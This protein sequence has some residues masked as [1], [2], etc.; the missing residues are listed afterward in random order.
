MARG[1]EDVRLFLGAES[2]AIM[3]AMSSTHAVFRAVNAVMASASGTN[4]VTTNLDHP[5]VYDSSDRFGGAYGMQRRVARL[6]PRTGSVSSDA[7][8]EEVDGGTCL[9]GIVHASNITGA[10][11]DVK[12]I[13]RE[14]RMISPDVF[15]LVD[16]VQYVPHAPV[17]VEDLGIDAYVFGPYKAFCVKGIG[18]AFLSDRLAKLDHWRL[19]GKAMDDWSLG[20]PED[21]T[22]AAWSAVVDYLCWLGSHFTESDKRRERIV[23]AMEACD[24]HLKALLR[25]LLQGTDGGPGLLQMGH[26]TVHGMDDDLSDRACLVL[27]GLD[28]MDSYQAVEL[29]N[30]AG[31]RL[32]NRVR[33]AY[34]RHTLEA[35]GIPGGVRLSACHYNTPEEIDRFLR[36][37]AHLGEISDGEIDAVP[38]G[39]TTDGHS[40]G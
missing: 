4:V 17:D 2:G 25:R 10:V 40:E 12:T 39:S 16:G 11:M 32:H 21:A 29:Y 1:L 31:F 3:P 27:F 15:V 19:V 28:R 23:A 20:S 24:A 18:F 5:S 6:D 9:I 26:A 22:Y 13:T 30:R 38:G 8:L 35:L 34:S 7:I 14:A 37:T 36:Y 33:D